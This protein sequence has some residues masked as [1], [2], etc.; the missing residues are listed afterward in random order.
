MNSAL[1]CILV[2]L[3]ICKGQLS[4]QLFTR[5]GQVSLINVNR[6]GFPFIALKGGNGNANSCYCQ[7]LSCT[8]DQTTVPRAKIHRLLQDP[9][10]QLP[11]YVQLCLLQ[12]YH[13]WIR[14]SW[15]KLI[16]WNQLSPHLFTQEFGLGQASLQALSN[17]TGIIPMMHQKNYRKHDARV[18]S[19]IRQTD[20][21]QEQSRQ[22]VRQ[23]YLE[24]GP[25]GDPD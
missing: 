18:S 3:H 16:I 11:T 17:T 23:V 22:A 12:P 21:C 24:A 2:L 10:M 15:N 19:F 25:S 7:L 20:G 8:K 6:P 1:N 13:P 14:T 9:G 4:L 5:L